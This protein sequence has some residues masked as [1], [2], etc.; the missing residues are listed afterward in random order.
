MAAIVALPMSLA[1]P[2]SVAVLVF[3]TPLLLAMI[4]RM[5]DLPWLLG[6]A[7]LLL[8]LLGMAMFVPLLP[9]SILAAIVL[10]AGPAVAVIAVGVPLRTIDVVAAA[11]FLASAT[12]AVIAGFATVNLAGSALLILG[13][14]L[15]GLTIVLVRLSRD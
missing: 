14:G 5:R 8:V 13:I 12:I 1:A 4:A 3:A 7:F 9:L 10:F 11:A 15:I 2:R 6:V